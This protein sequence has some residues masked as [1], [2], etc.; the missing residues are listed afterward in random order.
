MLYNKINKN[1]KQ[2][3]HPI[4]ILGHK[5]SPKVF[6]ISELSFSIIRNNV[7]VPIYMVSDMFGMI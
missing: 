5:L 4:I 3:N 1:I 2:N 6:R 7:R